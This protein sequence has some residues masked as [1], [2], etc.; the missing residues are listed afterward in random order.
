MCPVP[1]DLRFD[2]IDDM[3]WRKEDN[4]TVCN[5]IR[6]SGRSYLIFVPLYTAV[7]FI[8][9]FGMTYFAVWWALKA[10]NEKSRAARKH[11]ER[12]LAERT[13]AE[14]TATAQSREPAYDAHARAVQLA[15]DAVATPEA[16]SNFTT[17]HFTGSV[18]M[19]RRIEADLSQLPA[20]LLHRIK[21]ISSYSTL[22]L[23]GTTALTSLTVM[24]TV[25]VQF[26]VCL[27]FLLVPG[28]GVRGNEW[29]R[30]VGALCL[31]GPGIV[32]TRDPRN[33][34]GRGYIQVFTA[35]CNTDEIEDKLGMFTAIVLHNGMFL[36]F[37]ILSCV[38][39]FMTEDTVGYVSGSLCTALLVL[40]TLTWGVTRAPKGGPEH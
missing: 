33:F 1:V 13:S 19:E 2:V 31:V 40:M 26:L 35:S 29:V 37:A 5:A 15:D 3:V 10:A 6:D 9:Y 34:F 20:S 12:H 4:N 27:R 7:F 22:S 36:L 39:M 23:R 16:M 25:S 8:M 30:W 38:S 32:P 21:T 17:P 24:T 28:I 11:A 14:G 18:L